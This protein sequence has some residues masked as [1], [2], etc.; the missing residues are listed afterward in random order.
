MANTTELPNPF[1]PL[2]FLPPTLA[3]QF[4]VSRYL[5][6]ATLGAYA[7]D[8]ALNIGN[9]F[10]LLFTHSIR[11]STIAYFFSRAVTLAYI[12]TS[13][14][15]QVSPVKD[16]AALQLALG[17]CLV[18]S[19]GATSLLFFL[20]V[21]AVWYPNKVVSAVFFVLWLGVIGAH[22]T[23]PLGIRGAHIGPTMQCIN[24][25]VP[26]YAQAAVILALVNDTAVFFAINYRI[27][28][29]TI[30]A[31]SFQTRFRVFFGGGQ[32][33]RLSRALVQSGQHFYLVAV[34]A[35]VTVLVLLNLPTLPAVYHAM[36]AIPAFA[37]VN[38][39]ACLVFRKIKFGLISA[40]GMPLAF[41]SGSEFRAEANPRSLSFHRRG[42]DPTSA[43]FGSNMT[44]PMDIRVHQ[45]T[46]KFED[47]IDGGQAASKIATLA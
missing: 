3:S 30:V 18:L 26:P 2:A 22:I 25:D 24:T 36:L 5:Y 46:N 8:M 45:E 39:M 28:V 33:S 6:A 12:L 35:N 9:D 16:C 23:A 4:E 44:F 19:Q 14:F 13:F 40:D 42:N 29:H 34:C 27:L 21:T 43:S 47:N 17:I 7:W 38:A 37:L 41:A 10:A 32:L 15:F 20:R 31:D 1:T 11:F